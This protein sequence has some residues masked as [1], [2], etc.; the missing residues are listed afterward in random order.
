MRNNL[1]KFRHKLGLTQR[2]MGAMFG[3]NKGYWCFLE[4]AQRKGDPEMW[5]D[6]GIKFNLTAKELKKLMEVS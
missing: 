4:N 2:E 6:L 5:I 1:I 3:K